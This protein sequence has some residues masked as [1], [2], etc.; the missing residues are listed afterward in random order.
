MSIWG[1]IIGGTAGFALGGPIGAILGVMVGG[2]FD[3]SA[4]RFTNT[5]QIPNK[6][7]QNIFALSIIILSA[8]IAKA[9]GHVTKDEI[10]AFKDKF[11]IPENEMQEVG[12]I[13]NEAKKSKDGYEQIANQV[14]SLFS[15]NKLLLEELLNN[16]FYI[17]ESDGDTSKK[18]VE[19]LKSI[20]TSLG[21]SENDFQRI[22]H[23]RLNIK[24]SDPYKILSV[25]RDDEDSTIRK[26]W[27][28]LSKE[29]HPDNLV[30]RG[31]PKEFIDQSNDELSSINLAYDKIK[32]QREIN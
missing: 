19:I 16:L 18:E 11:K 8:K 20:S 23:A 28:Q 2:S 14:G 5:N 13:F 29:H 10:Y 7:K 9:D 27:I 25:N 3:R 17:A 21:L 32:E 15:D 26:R 12:K 31:L 22:F 1:K 30:A 24:D 4:K 6:Q